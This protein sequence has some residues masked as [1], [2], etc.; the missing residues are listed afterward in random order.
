MWSGVKPHVDYFRTFGCVAHVHISNQ[1]ISKLNAKSQQCAILGVSDEAKTYK[2]FDP[3][4]NKVIVSKDVVFE[5][6]KSWHWDVNK[7]RGIPVAL[8]LGNK[9]VEEI[10]NEGSAPQH[11]TSSDDHF[12]TLEPTSNSTPINSLTEGKATRT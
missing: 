12:E 9:G 6:D 11:I 5:E 10:A 7:D 3:I 8:D 4:T 2:L 1:K